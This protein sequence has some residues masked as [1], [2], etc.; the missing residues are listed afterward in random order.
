M[1]RRSSPRLLLGAY[2]APALR[3]ALL[4]GAAAAL[5]GCADADPPVGD[6]GAYRSAQACIADGWLTAAQC[7]EAEAAARAEH[8]G[9]APRY[10]AQADC[11]TDYDRCEQR[12][13][14]GGS[15]FMP[16][17]AGYMTSRLIS[18]IGSGRRYAT[19]PLYGARGGDYITSSGTLVRGYGRTPITRGGFA[20]LATRPT[21]MRFASGATQLGRHGA[22]GGSYPTRTYAGG[23]YAGRSSVTRGGFGGSGSYGRGG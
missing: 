19:R 18:D 23:N 20:S 5:P 12:A 22:V 21:P 1:Q 15:F 4:A 16:F 3:G 14:G 11:E 8:E 7:Q 13:T 10:A 17:F 6:A 9:L 2:A